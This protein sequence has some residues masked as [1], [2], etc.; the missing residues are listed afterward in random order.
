M[1][2]YFTYKKFKKD[3]ARVS[4]FDT[5]EEAM[6]KWVELTKYPGIEAYSSVDYAVD[7]QHCSAKAILF[8][9][10]MGFYKPEALVLPNQKRTI[11]L[12]NKK[13]N[14]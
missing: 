14:D 9:N 11:Y 12:P 1:K 4:T 5:R 2:Y 3:E 10:D 13:K 6:A 7:D 8:W